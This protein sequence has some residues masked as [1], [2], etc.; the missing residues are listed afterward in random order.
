MD[1]TGGVVNSHR[2][3]VRKAT[4]LFKDPGTAMGSFG[5]ES[6]HIFQ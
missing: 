2:R 5:A 1:F 3:N 6:R 4:K